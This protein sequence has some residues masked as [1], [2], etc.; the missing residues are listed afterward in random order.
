MCILQTLRS[1]ALAGRAWDPVSGVRKSQ[2]KETHMSTVQWIIPNIGVRSHGAWVW[3]ETVSHMGGTVLCSRDRT[4]SATSG[5][6]PHASSAEGCASVLYS[7]ITTLAPFMKAE[8]FS[9]RQV[10]PASSWLF[11]FNAKLL[12]FYTKLIFLKAGLTAR[13]TGTPAR[14]GFSS[15]PNGYQD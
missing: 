5:F 6:P 13:F 12:V 1:K 8:R 10:G 7:W 15:T 9:S 4:V 14:D 3:G 11:F 2:G